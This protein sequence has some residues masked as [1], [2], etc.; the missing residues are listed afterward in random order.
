M[1]KSLKQ[2]TNLCIAESIVNIIFS[3]GIFIGG[4]GLIENGQ[5]YWAVT[6]FCAG[7]AILI[8]GICFLKRLIFIKKEID[9][10]YL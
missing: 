3:I 4:I 10:L 1:K 8:M 7:I 6:F 2:Y 9:N 5:Y